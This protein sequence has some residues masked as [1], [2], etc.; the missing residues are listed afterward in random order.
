MGCFSWMYADINENMKMNKSKDSYLLVPPEFHKKYGKF[1]KETCY[2]GYGRMGSYDVYEL[3]LE[4]NRKYINVDELTDNNQSFMIM[5][6]SYCKGLSDKKMTALSRKIGFGYGNP[7]DWKRLLGIGIACYD[8]Q[9]AALK[10]PI[11]ICSKYIDY[12]C[13]GISKGDPDQGF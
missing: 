3:V 10:Y 8:N 1:I 11:K 4:W 12:D 2:D 13:C 6:K 7:D 5:I 9:N